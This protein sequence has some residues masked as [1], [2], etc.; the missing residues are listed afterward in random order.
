MYGHDVHDLCITKG[1]DV[2]PPFLL[3]V[4]ECYQDT[5]SSFKVG[6]NFAVDTMP[7]EYLL[8]KH[9]LLVQQ[10]PII[11]A[12]FFLIIRVHIFL[13]ENIRES[14]GLRK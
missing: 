4:S 3:F 13:I 12:S 7:S 6:K 2:F 9:R 10:M 5:S 14:E 8:A 1:V 11:K